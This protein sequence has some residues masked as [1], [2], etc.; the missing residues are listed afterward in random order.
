MPAP[1]RRSPARG[2]GGRTL[3]L[4][5]SIETLGQMSCNPSI[6]GIGK[7]HLVKEVDALGGA[8]AHRHRRGR[9]PVPHPQL[10]QG[11]AVRATRAQADRVLYRRRS[12]G[13][14]RT[15]PNLTLFQQA[16]DDL[17][18]D[19]DRR[20]PRVTGVV[21]QIGLA[22]EADAVVL[23]TGTFLSGLIHVGLENYEAGRA[24][25]PPAKTLGARLRELQL[26]V[27]RLKT[28]TPPR[29]DGR[30]IDFSR[31][32]D[33]ARRRSGAG[34]LASWARATMHPRAGA[35]LD[36]AH[37]RAH[38][39][40]HSRRA[41]SLAAVHRRHQGRRSAL[42]PVDRGQ[43]RALR[44]AHEPSDLPRARRPRDATRSIRTASRRRCRST[45]SWRSC[46]RCRAASN[47]HILRPGYSI[48]YDYFDPRALQ[49][50]ARNQGDRADCSSPARSTARPATRKP[51]RRACSPASTPR[52]SC[53][54]KT[55]GARGATKRISACWSTISSR[56]ACPSRTGCS[57]RAP[58]TGC[59]CARTTPTCG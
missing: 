15:Q 52:A 26:P 21:T 1:R 50:D 51:R 10:E 42:L 13:G 58:S 54:A 37:E 22:F 25:D 29:L 14:S 4:T 17:P 32:R 45:C 33:A 56:A 5:H 34:V 39:R 44:R 7:G 38:A 18:L 41:R 47:A 19:G 31:A 20:G 46:A 55:A 59:S 11:P 16:V 3:L 8:M 49:V 48:E 36:H 23:T 57:R 35:V 28:G 2:W 53:A 40:D 27:G 6:G 43:G 12:A 24:G 30:T 9:H